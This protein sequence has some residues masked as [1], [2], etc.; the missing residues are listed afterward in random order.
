MAPDRRTAWS[1]TQAFLGLLAQIAND[2]AASRE[3]LIDTPAPGVEIV[4][5]G[6]RRWRIWIDRD[7]E[8][9]ATPLDDEA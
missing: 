6:G 2:T 7:G 1:L 5:V 8:R 9:H 3:Q 4:R